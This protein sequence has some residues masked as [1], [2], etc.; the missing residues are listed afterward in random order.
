MRELFARAKEWV[1]LD[2]REQAASATPGEVRAA[3]RAAHRHLDV[4]RQLRA[5]QQ[6]EA[7]WLTLQAAHRAALEARRARGD[8]VEPTPLDDALRGEERPAVDARALAARIDEARARVLAVLEGI[9]P[10]TPRELAW[11]RG[12]RAVTAGAAITLL[13]LGAHH[14]VLGPRNLARG[15]PVSSSLESS[16]SP[17]PLVN[18]IVEERSHVLTNY[19][20]DPKVTVDLGGLHRVREV[21]VHGRADREAV[22]FLPLAVEVSTDGQHFMEIARTQEIFTA[23]VPWRI[24]R[25]VKNVRYVRLRRLG[26]GRISLSELEVLGR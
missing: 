20:S 12:V 9:E 18:G 5:A 16:F 1:L 19:E 13:L 7:A 3:A 15:K 6:L 26:S 2:R 10:R 4:A 21:I 8:E 11:E 24:R 14:L 23:Y 17:N 22:D 25:S